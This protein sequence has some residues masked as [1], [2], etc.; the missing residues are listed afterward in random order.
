MWEAIVANHRRSAVLIFGMVL[1]LVLIGYAAGMMIAGP[2][3][4]V[5]GLLVALVI[6]G[7]MLLIY[8]TSAE[9]ILMHGSYARELK[10]EDSPALFNVVDEMCLAS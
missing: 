4:G 10:R 5:L 6:W 7:V 1:I 9:S 2:D 3:A 8:F